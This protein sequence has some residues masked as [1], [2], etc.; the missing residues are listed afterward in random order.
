MANI[1]GMDQ[2]SDKLK[3]TLS[4]TVSLTFDNKILVK[5]KKCMRLMFTHQRGRCRRY[6]MNFNPLSRLHSAQSGI[7]RRAASRWAMPRISG[8]KLQLFGN[9]SQFYNYRS[10]NFTSNQL[11]YNY[12]Y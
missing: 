3:T 6:E 5:Q 12:N 1:S 11:Y 7:R 2:D 10:V 8:L 4:T 9:R